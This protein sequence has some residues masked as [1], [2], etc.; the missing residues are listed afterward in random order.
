MDY[1]ESLD[2]LFAQLPMFSRV[3][4]AAYKPGLERSYALAE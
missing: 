4:A 2:F 3:G 1:K